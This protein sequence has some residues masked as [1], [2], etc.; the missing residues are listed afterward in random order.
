MTM[1]AD[2]ERLRGLAEDSLANLRSHDITAD[3]DHVRYPV[4]CSDIFAVCSELAAARDVVALLEEAKRPWLMDECSQELD[5]AME[6]VYDA[7]IR[8][9]RDAALRTAGGTP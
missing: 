4:T 5:D 2:I 9:Y 8:Y 3:P 7:V 6:D 1:P